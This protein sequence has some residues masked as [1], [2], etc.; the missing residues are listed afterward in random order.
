[1]SWRGRSTPAVRRPGVGE[2]AAAAKSGTVSR[3]EFFE[4]IERC[5]SPDE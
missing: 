4:R 2:P 3:T 5:L 1:L